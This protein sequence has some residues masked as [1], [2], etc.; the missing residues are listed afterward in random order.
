MSHR[1]SKD[2]A[3]RTVLQKAAARIHAIA[4]A[5]DIAL[6]DDT[7]VVDCQRCVRTIAER[8][9][10]SH[11]VT[12]KLDE[13]D[14]SGQGAL[15]IDTAVPVTLILNELTNNCLSHAFPAERRGR[16]GMS[17]RCKDG[18]CTLQIA[19]DGVGMKSST[20]D[21][22]FGMSLVRLLTEQLSGSL[23]VDSSEGAGTKIRVEF[24]AS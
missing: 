10:R 20:L 17:L 7:G 8:V 4:L 14:I 16:I 12:A 11:P 2:D 6:D 21:E 24:G 19:D 13:V 18:A 3:A 23:T 22:G 9:L 1:A 5:Y 15:Q